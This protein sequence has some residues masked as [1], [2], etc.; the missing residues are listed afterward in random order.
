MALMVTAGVGFAFYNLASFAGHTRWGVRGGFL[1]FI[2][3]LSAYSYVAL[4]LPGSEAMLERSAARGIILTTLLGAT[5]GLILTWLW[6]T[7]RNRS[8]PSDTPQT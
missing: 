5:A 1:A 7:I 2:G 3:G 4:Q 6:R 8:T